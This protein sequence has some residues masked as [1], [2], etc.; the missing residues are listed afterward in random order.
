MDKSQEEANNAKYTA[1]AE[2]NNN[3]HFDRKNLEFK[4]L[5]NHIYF[6]K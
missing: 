4:W 5:L 2:D 1:E 3:Q 6:V